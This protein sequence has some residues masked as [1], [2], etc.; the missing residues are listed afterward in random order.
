MKMSN[1]TNSLKAIVISKDDIIKDYLKFTNHRNNLTQAEGKQ[2]KNDI[3]FVSA[4]SPKSSKIQIPKNLQL[5]LSSK[6]SVSSFN[7]TVSRMNIGVQKSD[8]F[9]N[10]NTTE[11]NI[12]FS[13]EDLP[14]VAI[15]STE[16]IFED[17]NAKKIIY[18]LSQKLKESEN[19]RHSLTEELEM[20]SHEL[21]NV[22]S[23]Y[24][25]KIHKIEKEK[26]EYKELSRKSNEIS[27]QLGEEVIIL[28]NQLDKFL[29]YKK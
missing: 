26:D 5:D 3:S 24:Q 25:D 16:S 7:T 13:T 9:K 23:K 4:S 17:Q 8:G 12:M 20:L 28:R 2:T 6:N 22:H 11:N 19:S 21:I 18:E 27:Q 29:H 10:I 14:L 1:K 15:K